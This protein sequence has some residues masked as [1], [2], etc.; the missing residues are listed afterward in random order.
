MAAPAAVRAVVPTSQ[1]PNSS[2]EW[3]NLLTS[4]LL[5]S[6]LEDPTDFDD[7]PLP[8][9]IP[10]QNIIEDGDTAQWVDLP[11]FISYVAKNAQL[12][13]PDSAPPGP[14]VELLSTLTSW[15]PTGSEDPVLAS[16]LL[17]ALIGTDDTVEFYSK[18]WC[19]SFC[20]TLVY[21]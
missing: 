19:H 11:M 1:S 5:S 14:T 13:K 8:S 12:S 20:V 10:T 18:S 16:M 4:G 2:Q 15:Y 6:D 17:P 7:T 3:H 21:F 9:V